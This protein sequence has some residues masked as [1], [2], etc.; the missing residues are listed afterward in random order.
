V[1]FRWIEG[2][3]LDESL[4]PEHLEQVGRFTARLHEHAGRFV[5]S[6]SFTRRWPDRVTDELVEK[7]VAAVSEM[8]PQ[9]DVE[10]ARK[11]LASTQSALA[12]LGTGLDAYGLIHADLHQANYLF[13]NGEVRAIDFDDCGYAHFIYDL[14]VTLSEVANR[15]NYPEMRAALL[16]G[17]RSV[18]PLPEEHEAY[19]PVLMAFRE[20]QLVKWFIEERD[21]P[22]FENWEE[23][24]S[25]GFAWMKKHL[26]ER[27]L[28][29]RTEQDA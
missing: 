14:A 15:D 1:L 11:A 23:Y 21:H 20:L 25:S 16:K 7:I 3:F 26:D 17:Y 2:R 6:E 12:E 10:L 5:P 22:A 8:R 13:H 28:H 18:R 24:V 27:E 4:S 29:I 19:L 9:E